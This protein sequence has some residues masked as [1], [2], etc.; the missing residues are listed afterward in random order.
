M[1]VRAVAGVGRERKWSAGHPGHKQKQ[2]KEQKDL[3][4]LVLAVFLPAGVLTA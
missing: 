3:L 2:K 4:L 1:P